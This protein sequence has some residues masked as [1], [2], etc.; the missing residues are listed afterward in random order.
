MCQDGNLAR[1]GDN[2]DES[3]D[4]K[5]FRLLVEDDDREFMDGVFVC[6]SL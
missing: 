4:E 2:S 6:Y 1:Y 3:S 5:L